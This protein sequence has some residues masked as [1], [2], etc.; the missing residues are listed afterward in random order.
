MAR[1]AVNDK[2]PSP[3]V[4]VVVVTYES[5]DMLAE[6]LQAL[7]RQTF[8]DFEVVL[9][10]NASS[11]GAARAAAEADPSIIAIPNAM[12]L[13]FAAAVNQAAARAR[14]RWLALINPDAFAD[15]DW[16]GQLMG[17]AHRHPQ[18]HAF[19]SRQLM[20]DDPGRLDGLG[21]VMSAA[22]FPFRGGYGRRDPG[23]LEIG[24]SF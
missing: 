14:G 12:N 18:V 23:R 5:G 4:S 7:R 15:P 8:S 13:G 24:E 17:A 3:R 2:P 20:A 16:L 1:T 19:G 6:C 21:D 11:D 22:G 10:D 9:V